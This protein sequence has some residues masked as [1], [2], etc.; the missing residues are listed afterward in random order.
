MI[1]ECKNHI[2]F[3]ISDFFR[4]KLRQIFK[5]LKGDMKKKKVI[6]EC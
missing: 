1:D 4:I 6:D 3:Q 2:E 5:I